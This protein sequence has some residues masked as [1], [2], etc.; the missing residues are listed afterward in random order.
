MIVESA[1]CVAPLATG[2][3][4]RVDDDEETA[5]DCAADAEGEGRL[6]D[7]ARS[8]VFSAWDP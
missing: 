5:V 4:P 8:L 1:S 3:A 7:C 2:G 6:V